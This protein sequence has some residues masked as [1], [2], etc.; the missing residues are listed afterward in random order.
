MPLVW[1][2]VIP[3]IIFLQKQLW[4]CRMTFYTKWS[5]RVEWHDLLAFLYPFALYIYPLIVFD[6][7]YETLL[8]LFDFNKMPPSFQEYNHRLC[9]MYNPFW[10]QL[11]NK[12]FLLPWLYPNSFSKKM[13]IR[14][15]GVW[16]AD[17]KTTF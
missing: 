11:I 9:L 13:K 8:F 10:L 6:I 3:I 14:M 12:F 2:K 7:K 5:R 15:M 1:L 4:S 16:V 17:L